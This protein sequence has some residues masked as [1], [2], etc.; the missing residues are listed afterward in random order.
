MSWDLFFARS[1]LVTSALFYGLATRAKGVGAFIDDV[2]FLAATQCTVFGSHFGPVAQS[3]ALGVDGERD[4]GCASNP[5]T[6]QMLGALGAMGT[7][8]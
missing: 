3:L 4:M 5:R 1:A 2:L 7:L 8:W 6:G